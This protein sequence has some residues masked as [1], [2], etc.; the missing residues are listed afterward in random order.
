MQ[1]RSHLS[2]RFGAVLAVASLLASGCGAPADLRAERVTTSAAPTSTTAPTTTTVPVTTTS[3]ATVPATT[4]TV[5][6]RTTSSTTTSMTTTST[7]TPSTTTTSAPYPVAAAEADVAALYDALNDGDVGGVLSHL[8]A[9]RHGDWPGVGMTGWRNSVSILIDGGEAGVAVQCDPG[10]RTGDGKVLVRC[11]QQIVRDRL[12]APG[13]VTWTE[14]V[15]WGADAAGLVP[16]EGFPIW[17]AE[18]KGDARA[19]LEDFDSWLLERHREEPVWGWIWLYWE[20]GLYPSQMNGT[21]CGP[22]SVVSAAGAAAVFELVP[23]FLAGSGDWPMVPLSDEEALALVEAH[24]EALNTGEVLIGSS[25]RNLRQAFGFNA[26]FEADC[27][28]E[29]GRVLCVELVT[30]DFYGP[31]GFVVEN[32]MVYRI[33]GT[34]VVIDRDD[35]RTCLGDFVN[36]PWGSMLDY[37]F[38]FD[39]WLLRNH[40]TPPGWNPLRGEMAAIPCSFYPVTGSGWVD[41]LIAEYVEDFVEES[42]EYPL[43]PVVVIVGRSRPW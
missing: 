37:V 7:K 23:E 32:T 16:V 20:Q 4:T 25:N 17:I 35:S 28:V 9:F 29:E 10:E 33:A 42:D 5:P 22:Y 1:A 39:R 3:P 36:E 8:P 11:D 19:Y 13:G 18:P 34:E 24:Y 43:G 15:V 21:T 38:A 30:D 6:A 40:P 41:P 2:W 26:V 14:T 31:A 27:R 12:Y